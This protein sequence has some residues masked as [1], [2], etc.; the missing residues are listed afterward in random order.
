MLEHNSNLKPNVAVCIFV[1]KIKLIYHKS[2]SHLCNIQ[3]SL[4]NTNMFLDFCFILAYREG[5]YI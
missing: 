3:I 4:F 1:K 2:F 5:P